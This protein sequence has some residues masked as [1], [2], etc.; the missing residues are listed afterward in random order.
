MGPFLPGWGY[1]VFPGNPGLRNIY[2]ESC[3]SSMRRDDAVRA[4]RC[5]LLL[6][7]FVQVGP[8]G[9][10]PDHLIIG[11]GHLAVCDFFIWSRLPVP[12]A[13]QGLANCGSQ[14]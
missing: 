7:A 1:R 14:M 11:P 8:P 2:A 9:L 5:R 4:V 3:G 6:Y 13:I 12:V 10:P